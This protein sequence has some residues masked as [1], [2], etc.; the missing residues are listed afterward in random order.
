MA[1]S[2]K[3]LNLWINQAVTGGEKFAVMLSDFSFTKTSESESELG[4]IVHLIN[5]MKC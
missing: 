4:C 3:D 5:I 2:N 1:K